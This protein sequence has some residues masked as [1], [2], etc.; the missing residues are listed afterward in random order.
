MPEYLQI[1]TVRA[2]RA[3]IVPIGPARPPQCSPHLPSAQGLMS[4]P[5]TTSPYLSNAASGLGCSSHSPDLPVMGPEGCCPSLSLVRSHLHSSARTSWDCIWPRVP[6]LGL[7]L[8]WGLISWLHLG[9]LS[10][11]HTC[12][13]QVCPAC[14][15][16][17]TLN[18]LFPLPSS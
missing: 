12:C 17:K 16:R 13:L 9:S 15:M 8:T 3:V 6:L 18:D 2:L 10:S 11:S 5:M 7:T 14:H 4:N 1:D